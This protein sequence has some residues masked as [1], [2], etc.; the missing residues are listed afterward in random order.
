MNATPLAVPL[1]IETAPRIIF[2]SLAMGLLELSMS[3]QNMDVLTDE[4]L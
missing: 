3:S 2:L 1:D 4:G